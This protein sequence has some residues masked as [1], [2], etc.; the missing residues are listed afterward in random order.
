MENI[1]NEYFEHINEITTTNN[2]KKVDIDIILDTE[3]TKNDLAVYL[4]ILRAVNFNGNHTVITNK[5]ITKYTGIKQDKQSRHIEKLM[6]K[7][8]VYRMPSN[9]GYKYIVGEISNRFI[10]VT[11]DGFNNLESNVIDYTRKLRYL[12]LS[13][14]N[15]QLPSKATV[16]KR[17]PTTRQEYRI[18]KS[19]SSDSD[20]DIYGSLVLTAS[21]EVKNKSSVIALERNDPRLEGMSID[22]QLDS[23]LA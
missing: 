14:G 17:F 8:Y 2:Y 1:L 13:D 21:N 3:L 22:E 23:L 4:A 7:G 20:V 11:L 10:K 6:N 15:D 12:A 18:M 9:G 16:D 5:T 19:Y